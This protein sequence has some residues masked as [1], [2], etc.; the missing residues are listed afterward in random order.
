MYQN[1]FIALAAL[2][3]FCSLTVVLTGLIWPTFMLSKSRPFSTVI[4]F[5][6]LSDLLA[7]AINCLGFPQ[8]GTNICSFQA[9]G[10]L[11]FI[12]ASWLWT[13]M[14]VYLLRTLIIYKTIHLTLNWMHVICWSVPVIPAFLPLTTNP[15][16]QDD[17][18]NGNTPCVL[19]GNP[20]TKFL[21]ITS[22]DTGLA[23]ICFVLMTIWTVQIYKYASVSSSEDDSKRERALFNSMKLYPLVLF[24]TWLPTFIVDVLIASDVTAVN[25]QGM[26][27]F[28]LVFAT[29]YGTL[30]TLIYFSQSPV[31]RSLWYNLAVRT[32]R[33]SSLRSLDMSVDSQRLISSSALEND[34]DVLVERAITRD[35]ISAI[36]V[37][38][39]VR[40]TSTN[41][42]IQMT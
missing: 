18:L 3:G 1:V 12:P 40:Q 22:C 30:L 21:W 19:G 33:P 7:S 27:L 14:L 24:I 36:D 9:F 10:Y 15:Y 42:M 25:N 28:I 2:S 32:F 16:G 37:I 13:L 29:Q 8:N 5:I 38:A 35:S 20:T 34:E 17:S 31:A 41:V 26:I 39:S 11:Y 23:F 6:S 4:F